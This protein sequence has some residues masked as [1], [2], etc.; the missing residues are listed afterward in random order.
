MA[1]ADTPAGPYVDRSSE[2]VVCEVEEGGSIDA[3][4][5][6]ASDGTAYLY[7]KNDGNHIG[8]DTFLKVAPLSEDGL[9]LDAEPTV[10]FSQDLP[11]EGDIVE[12]PFVWE[13][14]GIFHLFYSANGYWTDAYAVGHATAPS[15]TGPFT[16][17][18]DPVL[19]TSDVA[20]GPGHC[21]L[22][23]V[24][25]QVWMVYHA[26]EPGAVGD[27]AT[28][29][30]MWLSRVSFTADGSVEVDPPATQLPAAPEG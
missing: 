15:P 17:D 20:A 28:G 9:Q 8:V 12:A 25:G 19:T 22:I 10:L 21:S 16:K 7:W 23:E 30:Q 4:P 11:W 29:R 14:D 5:F 2:P 24:G 18:P 1:V 6:V 26:W 13:N 3:S 27:E